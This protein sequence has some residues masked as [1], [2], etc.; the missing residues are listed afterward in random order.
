MKTLVAKFKSIDWMAKPEGYMSIAEA[1]VYWAQ[2]KQ[3]RRYVWVRRFGLIAGLFNI[4]FSIG[5]YTILLQ[6]KSSSVELI[7]ALAL[8]IFVS[9]LVGYAAVVEGFRIGVDPDESF[10]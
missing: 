8:G 1:K 5:A 10:E 2:L 6:T 9:G 7:A 4:M 3:H